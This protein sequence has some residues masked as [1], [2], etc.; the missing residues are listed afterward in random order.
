MENKE[1]EQVV[2]WMKAL[3]DSVCELICLAGE[4]RA[5]PDVEKV[6]HDIYVHRT[7]DPARVEVPYYG[8]SYY[9]E[10]LLRN[11]NEVCWHIDVS[12]DEAKWIIETFVSIPGKE[13]SETIKEFPNRLAHSVDELIAELKAGTKQLVDCAELIET[14]RSK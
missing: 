2:R 7:I 3:V 8:F 9:V 5:L 11:G 10:V 13:C 1:N 12:W 14:Q 4:F 6:D